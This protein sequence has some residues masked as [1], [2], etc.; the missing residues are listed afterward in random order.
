MH[1][2]YG[3]LGPKSGNE[4]G[5]VGNFWVYEAGYIKGPD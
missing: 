2:C 5:F 1:Q 4:M 3:L